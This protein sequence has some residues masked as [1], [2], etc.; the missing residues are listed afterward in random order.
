MEIAIMGGWNTDSGASTHS[1]SIGREFVKLGHELNVF[2]FYH[3]AF[4]GS[5]LTGKDE[6]YVNPCFTHTFYNPLEL[7]PRPFLTN[8]YKF[9]IAEDIGMFPKDLLVK[10]YYSHLKKKAKCIMVYH[11]NRLSDDPGFYQ[12]DWD[13]IV[14]FDE[15]F[16]DVLCHVYP[17]DLIH[18]IPYPC[19]P[20]NPGDQAEARELLNLP[21]DRKIIFTFGGNTNR[22]L[23]VIEAASDLHKD[24]PVTILALTKDRVTINTYEE[25]SQK[26]KCEIIIR[27]E[28]PSINRLYKYLH[29]VDLL[30]Y[31]R[32]PIP[33]IVVASTILQCLGAGCPVVGNNTKFTEKFEG[34][35]F[36]YDNEDDL[37]K[38]IKHVFDQT[39]EYKSVLEKAQKYVVE[40][41][42]ENIAKKFMELYEKL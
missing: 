13:G 4:H 36:K 9:F 21:E 3:H 7:D 28:A 16:K 35:I 31:Y 11:D 5:Q 33:H 2:T 10:I 23:N 37:K 41:S 27:E 15:R 22:V 6:D 25:L 1:E 24:Y 20:W 34:E 29:A 14:C 19:L 39:Q 17:E 18:V 30:L 26:L 32:N 38:N 12:F 40:N 8:D 42:C